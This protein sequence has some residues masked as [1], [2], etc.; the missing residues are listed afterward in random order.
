MSDNFFNILIAEDNDVSREM[1]ANILKAKGYNVFGAIDGSS[2]I[3]VIQNNKIDMAFVDINMHPLGGFEFI[4]HLIVKGEKMPVVIV[5]S[6]TSGDTLMEAS[7]LGIKQLMNKPVNPE[8]LLMVTERVLSDAG[9]YVSPLTVTQHD[10]KLTPEGFMQKAAQLA[11]K[12]IDARV[13]GP[14]GLSLIHI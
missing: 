5:T 1:M 11:Q 3:E 6:D 10:T 4:K 13:G 9:H 12:N 7:A 2:A 8:R 14:F